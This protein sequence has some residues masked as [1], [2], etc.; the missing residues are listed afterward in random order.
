MERMAMMEHPY[1]INLKERQMV[2]FW[3]A[4]VAWGLALLVAKLLSTLA[5][6]PPTWL[7]FPG[8]L[9]IFGLLCLW[10][11]RQLWRFAP[12]RKLGIATPILAGKW[13]GVARSSHDEYGT[14]HPL[15]ATIH[16]SWTSISICVDATDSRSKSSTAAISVGL[17]NSLIYCFDNQ[18]KVG[19]PS[20]MHAHG[21]TATLRIELNKLEG[22][23]YSGRDRQ[24]MGTISLKRV[25]PNH[26]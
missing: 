8:V 12:I 9:T 13:S 16:Q 20:T 14:E 6:N 7:D 3:L 21:G 25:R 26:R 17:E 24:N 1:S 15:T 18:P 11:D 4:L 23:Y 22:E 2:Y 5:W 19:A 10:F